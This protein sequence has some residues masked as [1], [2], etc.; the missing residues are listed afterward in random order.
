MVSTTLGA[1]GLDAI[2]DHTSLL[3]A[4]D[5][6][7]FTTR[8]AALLTDQGLRARIVDAAHDH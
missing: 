4:N 2:N 6:S 5:A 7:G 1:E 8:A 3:L